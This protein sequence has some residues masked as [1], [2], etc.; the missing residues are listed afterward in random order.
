[1]GA[2]WSSDPLVRIWMAEL[3]NSVRTGVNASEKIAYGPAD[4]TGKA[5]PSATFHPS[6][7]AASATTSASRL[8]P[9]PVPPRM[10]AIRPFPSR[11]A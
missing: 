6:S 5:L 1:M 8:L 7:R 2:S 10:N 4:S 9:I 11:A 3:P